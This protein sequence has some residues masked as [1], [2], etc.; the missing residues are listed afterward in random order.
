MRTMDFMLPMYRS[1]PIL[2]RVVEVVRGMWKR[3]RPLDTLKTV[4]LAVWTLFVLI[5]LIPLL[6]FLK[7][8]G[9]GSTVGANVL[10]IAIKHNPFSQM[11]LKL[12][13]CFIEFYIMM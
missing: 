12:Y 2:R 13:T 9:Y 1:R 5:L 6:N 8:A 7:R 10:F 11:G 3:H 4:V